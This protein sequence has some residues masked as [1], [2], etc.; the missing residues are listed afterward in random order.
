MLGLWLE[1]YMLVAPSLHREGDALF[2]I[3][4]PMIA[5]LIAGMMIW[6]VRWF[7]STFPAIQLWQ[8]PVPLEMMESERLLDG[9]AATRRG[10]AGAP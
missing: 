5:C 6:S 2:P 10:G 7:L 3:W 8:P 1:R 4:H 9:G